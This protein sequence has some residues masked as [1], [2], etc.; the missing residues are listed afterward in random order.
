[1]VLSIDKSLILF[2]D[3]NFS[4]CKFLNFEANIDCLIV[5]SQGTIVICC[6][7]D[8]NICGVHIKGVVIFNVYVF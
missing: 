8:G 4:N 5:S 6:L 7:S 3:E 2:D 1:M